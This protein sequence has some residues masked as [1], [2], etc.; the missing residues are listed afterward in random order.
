[1][2]NKPFS[3]NKTLR[4]GSSLLDLSIPKIMGVINVTPDSFF[5]DSRVTNI[6]MA[7][8]KAEKM[9]TDGAS[10]LDIGG[11]STRPGAAEISEALELQRTIQVI[12]AIHKR[13]PQVAISIDT[14][15]YEVAKQALDAGA[16]MINDITGGIHDQRI[17]HLSK[18]FHAPLIIMH[19]RGNSRTMQQLTNYENL[20]NDI[21]L[22]LKKQ[23]DIALEHNVHDII[24]DPGF[25]FA[26][27]IEQ[28]FTLLNNM[29]FFEILGRPL[30]AGLS[31]KSMIWKTL[32]CAPEQAL[33]GTTSL[34][35]IALLKGASILRVHDVLEATECVKLFCKLV[36]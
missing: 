32:D 33:N 25:G 24:I 17:F 16:I 34:N 19:S 6:S 26:K 31:R 36:N 27:T 23:V 4:L 30:L 29:Q 8:A 22:H 2:Q 12:E 35:T 10:C 3:T 7:C 28:N 21:T 5:T 14:F 1:V 20:L 18:E 11:Y 15:R 13:F 9:I